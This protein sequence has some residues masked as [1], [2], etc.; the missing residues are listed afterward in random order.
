MKTRTLITGL[1]MAAGILSCTGISKT[2]GIVTKV[3]QEEHIQTAT[4]VCEEGNT[5]SFRILDKSKEIRPGDTL[6][7]IHSGQYAPNMVAEEVTLHPQQLAGG[8]RDSNGCIG[9]AGY[10]WCEVQKD[11][12]RL[13]EK[14][15]RLEAADSTS[16]SA[17]IVFAPDSAQ[18]E[19]F[20]S[21]GAENEI[22]HRHTLPTGAYAWNT[23]DDD[24]KN[25]RCE[26]DGQWT[27]SQRKSILFRSSNEETATE[28]GEI[29]VHTYEGLLPAASCPG[30]EY[31]LT[32]RNRQHSGNGTFM[33]ALI[34]KEAE[35]GKDQT[36]T[37]TGKRMTLR[38]I[39]EDGNATVWQCIS[40]DG[41]EI[42]NFLREN[43]NKL[44][45]LNDKFEKPQTQQ[46][47]SLTRT[48]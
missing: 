27:I 22:L 21:D 6:E 40:D 48:E 23:E 15:I 7:V 29:E 14:G 4:I 43:E 24:T 35:D 46:N 34:Y 11:C 44:T 31:I 19:L 32:I 9:S 8:H 37:Y 2:K 26:T 30:I 39:P 25:V 17:F 12:I 13:W 18:V 1:C 45:L 20:F 10:T 38:G 33:L 42:F 36:F 28:L 41:K 47:Y 16:R 3:A 5:L